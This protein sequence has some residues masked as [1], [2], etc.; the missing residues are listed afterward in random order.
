V[1]Y[2]TTVAGAA[3]MALAIREERGQGLGVTCLQDY[4]G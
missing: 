4:Y 2:T 3:A 1:P